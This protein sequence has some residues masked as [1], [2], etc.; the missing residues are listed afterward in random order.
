[1][2]LTLAV[3]PSGSRSRANDIRAAGI[4]LSI[5]HMFSQPVSYNDL[6]D[7]YLDKLNKSHLARNL[8]HRLERLGYSVTLTPQQ[9]AA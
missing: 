1:M 7:I 4:Y 2:G 6:G 9:I 3:I 5:Y 8:V